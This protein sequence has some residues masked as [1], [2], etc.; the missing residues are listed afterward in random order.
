MA[1]HRDILEPIRWGMIGCGA[2]TE[3]KSGPAFQR[4]EGSALAALAS[5]NHVAAEDYARRH[6]I[7]RVYERVDDLIRSDAIDAIYIAT[8]PESHK[9]L[10][11]KVA[12]AGKACCVEKPMALNYADCMSMVSAFEAQGIPLF[13]SYYRRSLPR[14]LQIKSWLREGLIGEPRDIS[15]HLVRPPM[16]GAAGQASS[17]R[18][19]PQL[20]PGGHFFD[21]ACHGFDLLH[22]LLG[23]IESAYGVSVNQQKLYQNGDA[24]SACWKFSSGALGCGSWNFGGN[25]R[26]DE[27]SIV[28]SKGKL[29][30][31]VF[32]EAP[33][34]L[35]TD[36]QEVLKIIENPP[37]IQID[38]VEKMVRTIRYGIAHPS[39]GREAAKTN[40]VLE[41]ILR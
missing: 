34:C 36:G 35:R 25:S 32:D 12:Q 8:P 33:V 4:A 18:S 28:G 11:L 17:W 5:R 27:M 21:L 9:W 6:G 26:G 30:F 24:V 10:A 20:L 1:V 41:R 2:V 37:H 29:V 38:H 16:I 15:W 19:D 39:P 31:S 3:I 7:A 23:D 14:F 22:F 40:L 13:V